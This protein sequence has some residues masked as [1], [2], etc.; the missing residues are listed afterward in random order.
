[1]PSALHHAQENMILVTWEH[2]KQG[3]QFTQQYD[4]RRE[5]LAALTRTKHYRFIDA[6]VYQSSGIVMVNPR[7][8]QQYK[9]RTLK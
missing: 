6:M 2:K 3:Y 5:F 8:L 7:N 1:M 9:D 4:S